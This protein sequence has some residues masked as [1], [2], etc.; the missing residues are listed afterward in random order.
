VLVRNLPKETDQK[1][2]N[3]MFRSHGN[4]KSC[5]LEV[6]A[7]GESRGFGYVQF[8]TQDSAQ[9]AIAALNN[10]KVGEKNIEVMIHAKKNDR[11]D[12]GDRYTNLYIQNLPS[13]FSQ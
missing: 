4:I 10:S 9:K 1:V 3:E 8:E 6:Y 7:N 5:K 11:E 13:D 2:L 12:Q